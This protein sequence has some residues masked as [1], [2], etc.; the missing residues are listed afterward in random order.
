MDNYREE[1]ATILSER[2][3]GDVEDRQ[4][5]QTFIDKNMSRDLLKIHLS[6][7]VLGIVRKERSICHTFVLTH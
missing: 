2:L 4:S 5:R 6:F 1:R 7:L 3:F